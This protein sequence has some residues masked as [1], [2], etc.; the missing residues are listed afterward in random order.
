MSVEKEIEVIDK[1][2]EKRNYEITDGSL[3]KEFRQRAQAI[4][5]EKLERL[6]LNN[7]SKTKTMTFTQY[8]KEN[9][10]T[11]MK[12]PYAN[13]DNIREVS[14]FLM[15]CSMIY[16][17]IIE[18]TA[19]MPDFYY[20]LI[21]KSDMV[22]GVEKDKFLKTYQKT[23]KYL[24]NI[25][26]KK[27]YSVAIATSLRDG[28]FYG[29]TYGDSD[30][31]F[32]IQGLDPKYCKIGGITDN[33]QY[34]V[35]FNAD[36]FNSG[37]NKEY[38]EGISSG[39]QAGQGL[40]DDVFVNGYNTYKNQGREFQWF[41]LPV[42]RTMCLI[43]S[44]STD[45]LYPY[46]L[47]L[48]IS[49][50][51]LIDL[52]QIIAD[53]TQLENYVLL[54]SKIP[55]NLKSEEIDDFSV[56]LDLVQSM[57]EMINEVVP[58]LVGTAYSPCELEVIRFDKNS[59]AQD[60]D[61]LAQSMS[62][63][64]NNMGLSQLVVSGGASTNSVGLSHSIQVDESLAMKFVDKLE[65]WT[66]NF[67]LD[68]KFKDFIFK[69]HRTSYFSRDDYT[70]KLKDAATLG[71]PVK[72]SYATSLGITPYEVMLSSAMEQNMGIESWTPL[73]SS[74]TQSGTGT[75]GAPE[76]AIDTLTPE[77]VAARDSGKSLTT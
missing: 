59:E 20:N 5:F 19:Q 51:D 50:L 46:Y 49:L 27:E 18:Y 14:R 1:I 65:K 57:Q 7:V 75:V 58:D 73:V 44:D 3:A 42:E 29:L 62:N 12:S 11:Y 35:F 32:F 6:M 53:K 25:N 34:V 26:F 17:K 52:E 66:N 31:S 21:Y 22:K 16:K 40:W 72:T 15:R 38:V 56:S 41:M 70:A 24:Q 9:I 71:V 39:A 43:A 28:V 67:L 60:T 2:P 8:T 64:F 69:F 54:L 37:N 77:G 68:M 47:P 36:F 74:Y 63:L 13:I 55:L 30:E 76:K 48:M 45:E 23:S 4:N 33:G 61:K 10:K